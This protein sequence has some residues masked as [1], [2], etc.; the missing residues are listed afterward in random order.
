MLLFLS[1]SFLFLFLSLGSVLICPLKCLIILYMGQERG[2]SRTNFIAL[3]HLPHGTIATIFPPFATSG[4][5]SVVSND[6]KICSICALPEK[7]NQ[8]VTL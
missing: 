4:L 3:V 7:L 5:T 6:L 8:M 2:G 1:D